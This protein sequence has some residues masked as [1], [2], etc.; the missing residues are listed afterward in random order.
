MSRVRIYLASA[1]IAILAITLI[2]A[3]SIVYA[4][5]PTF[6]WGIGGTGF[7]LAG[8]NS[9]VNVTGTG[10][11]QVKPGNP[12]VTGGGT[13]TTLAPDGTVTDSGTY[14][15][16]GLS[17]F[18]LAPGGVA[19]PT[20][21]AGLAFLNIEYSDG[22][23]GILVVSC[24]LPGTPASVPEGISASKGFINYWNGFRTGTMPFREL[25]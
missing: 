19:D 4:A 25:D 14:E 24:R 7:T 23:E 16:T 8:D 10:T 15:V 3:A 12:H 22:E 1:G 13:W 5:H 6:Q 9:R 20:L 21:H 2:T 11:F 18:D 17:R